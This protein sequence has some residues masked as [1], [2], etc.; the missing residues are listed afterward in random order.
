MRLIPASLAGI[1]N[2]LREINYLDSEDAMYAYEL[3][4]L[5]SMIGA[6]K[7]NASFKTC[8]PGEDIPLEKA[9]WNARTIKVWRQF[10]EKFKDPEALA[11]IGA[12]K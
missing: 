1:I 7:Y 6:G 5:L 2:E 9:H 3:H 8:L 4:K 10:Y 12:K 11:G